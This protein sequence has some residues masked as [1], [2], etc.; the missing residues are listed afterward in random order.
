MVSATRF[1]D[2]IAVWPE[3]E[4]EIMDYDF[5]TQDGARR[6]KQR[7]EEYWRERGYNVEVRLVEAGFMPAM[8]SARTDVRSDMTNGM[9]KRRDEVE[10]EQDD[11][12]ALA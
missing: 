3:V 10:F 12:M 6:L 11:R 1:T 8:R 9:P 7:I 2:R 4:E 5:C